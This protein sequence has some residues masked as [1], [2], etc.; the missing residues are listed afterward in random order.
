MRQANLN[1][2]KETIAQAI[3]ELKY[4]KTSIA[5]FVLGAVFGVLQCLY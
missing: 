3:R 1:T 5:L 2:T 4:H